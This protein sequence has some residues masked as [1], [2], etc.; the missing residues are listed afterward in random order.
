MLQDKHCLGISQNLI[1]L[2]TDLP[3]IIENVSDM[4]SPSMWAWGRH[5]IVFI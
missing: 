5:Q 3:R 1:C 2:V 4:N